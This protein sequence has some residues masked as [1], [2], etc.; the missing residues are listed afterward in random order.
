MN[1]KSAAMASVVGILPL[2]SLWLGSTGLAATADEAQG[3]ILSLGEVIQR[4]LNHDPKAQGTQARLEEATA[5]RQSAAGNYGPKLQVDG[6]LFYWNEPHDF[7][8]VDSSSLDLSAVPSTLLPILQP[9]IGELAKPIRFRDQWTSQ[10]QVSVVQPITQLY[11][12]H[13]GHQ[14]AR[15]GEVAA[16]HQRE[17]SQREV[18]YRATEAYYRLLTAQHLYQVAEESVVTLTAHLE[19]AKQYRDADMLGLDEYLAVEVELGNAVENQIK[20]RT[21]RQLARA[22]L[23]TLMGWTDALPFTLTDVDENAEPPL[24][25]SLDNARGSGLDH[26]SEIASLQAMAKASHEQS[27]MAWWQL[28]PQLSALGRY[29]HT[30]GTAMNNTN[31]WFVGGVLSWNLWDWGTTYYKARAAEAQAR[32]VAA[33]EVDAKD[34]IGLEITQRFLA[35]EAARERLNVAR[36]TL[37]Q[38][39]E[40]MRVVRMKFEQHTVPST[41]VLDSQ[42]RLSRAQANRIYAQYELILSVAALRLSMGEGVPATVLPEELV[43]SHNQ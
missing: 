23:A 29:Q 17:Q 27:K 36:M 34:L 24:P 22:A 2:A 11:S 15:E 38:A 25:P 19:Q 16:Q 7:L 10:L 5:T 1:R 33:R 41:T 3:K 32:Q 8:A 12:V 43:I 4:S 42:T 37:R 28:T 6:T 30:T 14:A 9:L 26:R 39:T 21:Q 20:A 35:I 31:E 40:A 13:H 18:I